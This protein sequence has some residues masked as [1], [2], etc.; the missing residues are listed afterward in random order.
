MALQLDNPSPQPDTAASKEVRKARVLLVD[1]NEE[2]LNVLGEILSNNQYDILRAESAEAALTL[3]TQ[4]SADVIVCDIMM[5]G[6]DGFALFHE[7][8]QNPDWM[9]VPFVFLTS[10]ANQEE[11][12]AGKGSGCDDYLTKP[13]DPEELLA[14]IKGRLALAAH[15]KKVS[16]NHFESYRK[17]IIHTLSHE[18]RTPLVSINTGTEL[19]L[20]KEH[21]L[22]DEQARRLLESIQRGGF[23]LERLV[24]DFMLMQQ[25]DLGHA[26]TSC[27]RFRRKQSLYYLVESAVESFQESFPESQLKGNI[28]LKL[29]RESTE[30][31]KVE[32][33]DVQIV[34]VIQHLLSNALKFG[35]TKN[36]IEVSLHPEGS[37]IVLAIRDFGPGLD[38][39]A[40]DKACETFS[41]I[42]REM[43]EQQGAGL[44]LTISRYFTEI[45]GGTIELL[46]P[47][48]GPGLV[49]KITFRLERP[50]R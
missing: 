8:R 47:E 41:Q 26:A 29:N 15:R 17:R 4:H 7:V 6:K 24:N 11:V 14:V 30:E 23:R 46:P 10:L 44:G 35:G 3:L 13:F 25:I 48:E 39:R 28:E 21:R 36:P 16:K 22:P 37:E 43:Y 33:Y 18:F 20:D 27:E 49:A 9:E 40:S 34:H 5:P 45:N 50:K 19:L 2:L 32:V 12:C 1:D 31:L 38:T 42:D